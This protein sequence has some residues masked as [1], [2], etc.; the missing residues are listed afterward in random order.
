M[1]L[2]KK[3]K[4]K[5]DDVFQRSNKLHC[6]KALFWFELV[7]KKNLSLV[8]RS[9]TRHYTSIFFRAI[10][11]VLPLLIVYINFAIPMYYKVF[12]V[13]GETFTYIND[14][15][16]SFCANAFFI[17][18]YLLSPYYA[19]KIRNV[20]PIIFTESF[21]SRMEIAREER[22]EAKKHDFPF[23]IVALG[24]LF[25]AAFFFLVCKTLP[26]D[27][28]INH[29]P[30]ACQIYYI[31]FSAVSWSI[32]IALL[33]MVF[34]LGFISFYCANDIDG[35]IFEFNNEEFEKNESVKELMNIIIADFSFALLYIGVAA[36]YIYCYIRIVGKIPI[37]SQIA[38][39]GD[40]LLLT[41]GAIILVLLI[42]L[43][44]PFKELLDYMSRKRHLAIYN[45]DIMAFEASDEEER[46]ECINKKLDMM[47]RKFNI[48]YGNLATI[49]SSV[50]I[51]GAG[52][53][54]DLLLK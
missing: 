50:L 32:F 2:C 17:L 53:F 4:D 26:A 21:R 15:G 35:D 44:V 42:F 6:Y 31:L 13:S 45:Y 20:Q 7:E 16:S 43:F 37:L 5:M 18:S 29:L 52:M 3:I 51:P 36:V 28:W 22:N 40:V 49:V 47:S 1:G 46:K 54:L 12:W 8:F 10:Y 48:S 24:G 23:L 30:K 33:V 14:W 19:E 25:G 27:S 38:S 34:E 41:F 9:I 11:Y 39:V